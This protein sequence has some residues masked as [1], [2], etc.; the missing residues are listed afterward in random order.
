MGH[1]K[2][3]PHDTL[4]TRAY[5]WCL[6]I[7][8]D[9]DFIHAYKFGMV[10]SVLMVLSAG[11]I[12]DSLHILLIILRSKWI[13]SF[14]DCWA[15]SFDRALLA[16]IRD[17]GLCPCPRCLI[18][19]SKLDQTG[20]KRD[21]KFQLQNDRTYLLDR[22][23]IARNAIYDSAAAIAGAAVNRDFF[24]PNTGMSNSLIL[25]I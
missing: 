10:V 6:E 25:F 15:N 19:K 21:S 5:A 4:S 8:L 20:T 14:M 16:T 11:Y 23:L 18:P 3:G 2:K 17:K 22:V 24:R 12:L 13:P 9:A 1:T 7:L